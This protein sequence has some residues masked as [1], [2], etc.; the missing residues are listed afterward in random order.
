V[1]RH[2][3]KSDKASGWLAAGTLGSAQGG[4]PPIIP[5]TKNPLKYYVRNPHVIV[6]LPNRTLTAILGRALARIGD[7]E[8]ELKAKAESGGAQ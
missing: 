4:Q 6:G 7:L 8:A 3:S 5:P 2:Y 1:N